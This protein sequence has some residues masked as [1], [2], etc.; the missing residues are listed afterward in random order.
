[1]GTSGT[2]AVEF[3][4]FVPLFMILVAGTV[5]FGY[6]I[7][8]GS[9]LSAAVSAGSQYTANNGAMVATDPSGLATAISSVV[10]NANGTN[11]ATST[12]NV[13]N[14]NDTTNC[15]CPTGLPG[16]W[17]WGAPV[18]CGNPCASGGIAGQFVTITASRNVS[19]LFPTFGLAYSDT[20]SR[21]A[22][23]ETQ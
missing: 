18:A 10:N 21:N 7:Y 12:V 4:I 5:D 14:G 22:I 19:A 8:S 11:W 1:M 15:Y 23:V 2:A 17:T 6:L 3:A 20:I 13:N 16:N 9:A